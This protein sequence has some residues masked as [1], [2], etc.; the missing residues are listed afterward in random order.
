VNQ[1]IGR[2]FSLCC[3][4][5]AVLVTMTAYWQI[6]AAP[7]LAVRKD[8]ARLVYR[9][10][11]IKRG[12]IMAGNSTTVLAKNV[13]Q[14]RNGQ[15][16]YL[17][18]YPF[19]SLFAHPVGYNTIGEGRTGIE[20]SYNDFLT[21]SND[22]LS[23]LF[24]TL[25]DR[26]TG[27]TITGNNLLTSLSLPAQRAAA[28]GLV[29]KRGAVVALD[30][31]TGQVLAMASTPTYNPNTVGRNIGKLSAPSAGAPLLNRVTQGLYAPGST[32]KI[33]TATAALE[34]GKFTPSTTID[35]GG[36]CITVESHPLC[37]AGGEFA[38]T[39]SLATAL[40]YSYNTVFAQV[41][42]QV[43]QSRLESTMRKYGFFSKPPLDY[44]SDEM[45]ASGLYG[46]HGVLPTGTPEDVG[47]VAIGQERLLATPMQMAEVVATIANQGVRVRPWMVHRVVS[48]SGKTVL[49]NHPEEV[50]RVMSP[51]TSAELTTMMRSVVEEGTGQAANIGNL[52][53]AGK[54]GTAETGVPGLNNAWFIAFAPAENPKIAVAVVVERT[55]EFG[56][57]ISAPI[58]ASVIDAYL[59]SGVAK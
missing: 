48:P 29:G 40:T 6:W 35:G 42:Q 45:A 12:L 44:P 7:S 1:R 3:I 24:D 39:V 59:S 5:V 46:P 50:E 57:T 58:A 38:G 2:L 25:G 23:T 8:N 33:V 37:N 22:D 36:S 51:Q 15:T 27:K 21:A 31:H 30:P 56:G 13:R 16:L 43:G 28:R 14:V 47:R 19:D 32:F 9:Q 18:R 17:R 34:S 49:E 20:L 52:S 41:G 53:V 11:T 26:I 55:P 54:T 10:L 4:G